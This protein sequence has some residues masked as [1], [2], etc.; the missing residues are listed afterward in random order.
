MIL[1]FPGLRAQSRIKYITIRARQPGVSDRRP[2]GAHWPRGCLDTGGRA[3]VSL[4]AELRWRTIDL[5]LERAV[6]CRLRP[7]AD[8]RSGFR[9]AVLG[10]LQDLSPQFQ[11]PLSQVGHRS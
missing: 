8:R 11:P 3:D 7:V 5:P 4:A 6:E 1:V 10:R 9:D 2:S